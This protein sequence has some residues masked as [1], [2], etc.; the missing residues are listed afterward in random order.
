MTVYY[1][2]Y[3]TILYIYTAA[4][5]QSIYRIMLIDNSKTNKIIT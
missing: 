1:G 4:A 3:I 2:D 5:K